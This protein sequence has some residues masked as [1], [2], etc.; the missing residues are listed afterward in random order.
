MRVLV[1]TNMYPSPDRPELGSFVRDQVEA[2][3]ELPEMDVELFAFGGGGPRAYA[4]AARALRR[5]HGGERY[6]AVHAHYGLSGWV[7]LALGQRPLAVT[8]HGTDLAHPR[9][10]PLSRRLARLVDL[11]ATVSATLA[12]ESGLASEPGLGRLAVLPCGVN[13]DRFRPGDRGAARRRLGLDPDGRY[14]LFP[15]DPCRPEKRHDRAAA[16]A[17]TTGAKLFTYEHAHPGVVPDYVN[18]ADAVLVPSEREGFGLGVLE[19]LACDVPVL[20]TRA[21]VAPLALEGVGG[22]LC[23]PFDRGTWAAAAEPHLSE[24]DARIEGRARARLFDRRR[25]AERVARALCEVAAGGASAPYDSEPT[26][27]PAPQP[28]DQ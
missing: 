18:A 4:R 1:V 22:A 12:R 7:A 6:D 3:R 2:L 5:A 10:G 24:P 14:L 15:A 21:G 20:A 9:V 23:A 11:P 19:A 13:L 26:E 28:S 17:E 8:Y 25:M 27:P 16:V